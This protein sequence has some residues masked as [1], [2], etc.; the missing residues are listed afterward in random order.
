VKLRRKRRGPISMPVASMGDI[1]FLLI[2]FFMVCSNFAKEANIRYKSPSAQDVAAVREA[3]LSVVVDDQGQIYLNGRALDSAATLE[4][5]LT[6]MLRDKT[7]AV[8]RNVL[9]K[10]DLN[11]A[12]K[13]FE[14]ALDAIVSA[15][16][17]VVA[18]GERRR[19]E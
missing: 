18:V 8:Q 16:G 14:P 9:F 13:V 5:M 4:G 6:S 2:I 1:A 15:G 3:G 17:V 10:C 11:V 19:K 7:D 12:R